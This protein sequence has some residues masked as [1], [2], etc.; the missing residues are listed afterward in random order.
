MVVFHSRHNET[1]ILV[2]YWNLDNQTLEAPLPP[3]SEIDLSVEQILA[4]ESLP[5]GYKI[6]PPALIAMP[7]YYSDTSPIPYD[8]YNYFYNGL[9]GAKEENRIHKC[10]WLWQS[11]TKCYKLNINMK[12][13]PYLPL[14]LQID[15]QMNEVMLRDRKS[16]QYWNIWI[17]HMIDFETDIPVEFIISSAC[18]DQ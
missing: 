17:K 15:H 8:V 13:V 16:W 12:I 5:L 2:R 9:L 3:H 1:K 6:V 7:S 4:G 18:V 14:S 10:E 11:F